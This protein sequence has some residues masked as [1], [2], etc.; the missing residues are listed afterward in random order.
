M[1]AVRIEPVRTEPERVYRA[2]GARRRARAAS[3][4]LTLTLARTEFK[5]RYFGSVAR[6]RLVAD[7]AAAVLRRALRVLHARSSMSARGI[8]HYGV[9]LLT[10]IILWNYFIEA[11]GNSVT[12]LVARE[13]L[14]R[15]IRFPRMVSRCRSR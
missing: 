5:L 11:T 2:L 15:K 9:Y 8:P 4:E 6:L 10:G 13:A 7:A 1:S 14:L 3:V 12:C